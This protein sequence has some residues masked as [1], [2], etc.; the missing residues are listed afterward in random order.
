MTAGAEFPA[1]LK[2]EYR[3]DGAAGSRMLADLDRALSSAETRFKSFSSEAQRQVDAALSVGRNQT[4]SLDLGVPEMRAAAQAQQARA[5]AAREVAAAT[6]LAAREDRATRG[7]RRTLAATR[8]A[9]SAFCEPSRVP[10][11]QAFAPDFQ[12]GR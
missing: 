6:A 12:V 9:A 5:I 7:P 4:G 3:P 2:L 1:F 10:C 8:S 11:A